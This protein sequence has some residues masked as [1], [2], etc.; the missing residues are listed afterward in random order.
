MKDSKS[1][2][3]N[4][5]RTVLLALASSAMALC[6]SASAQAYPSKPIKM[7]VPYAAGGSTDL[8]ARLIAKS[9]SA[10]LGQPVIVDNRAGAGG[11][12]GHDAVAKSAADG[13]T[14][15]FSAAGPL[16]VTP[17]TYPKLAY[18]PVNSFDPIMLVATQP[19]LLVVSPNMKAGS[20]A[21]LIKEAKA[22]KGQL[23]YGSFGNGSA[24]HL[25]AESFKMLTK[26]EMTHVP[27]K[28]SSPA[29]TGLIGGEIDLMFDVFSTAAPL[30][31]SGK[32]RPLAI[33]S[34][35][36][37]P[38]FPDVPTMEQA[39]VTGF[40]AGTWFGVLAP[41]GTSKQVIGQLN[42]ALNA[43]L[44]EKELRDTLASQGAIVRGGTPEQ[45]HDFFMAE[46]QKSGVLVK[47]VGIR[48]D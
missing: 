24:A 32:L 37:S 21:E 13:Y 2:I 14:L 10:R 9:L 12:I 8:T 30:A 18:D 22:R 40:E 26:V 46:Y 47:A 17:H 16:T 3:S 29:L 19:L 27:Y 15:L 35:E 5:R 44:T 11:S 34:Q 45:F 43:A 38:K 4:L 33:T 6:G 28:G 41:A 31:E 39:G 20:V 36:R 48:L 23:N 7:I 42:G 25:A 1:P